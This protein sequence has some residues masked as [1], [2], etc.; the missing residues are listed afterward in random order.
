MPVQGNRFISSYF[1]DNN[2][3]NNANSYFPKILQ[4]DAEENQIEN[5][6]SLWYFMNTRWDFIIINLSG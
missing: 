6:Y 3:I 1:N 5:Y 4:G 2:N